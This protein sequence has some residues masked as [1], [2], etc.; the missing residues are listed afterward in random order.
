MGKVAIDKDI[1]FSESDWPSSLMLDEVWL[2]VRRLLVHKLERERFWPSTNEYKSYTEKQKKLGDKIKSEVLRDILG[3][4]DYVYLNSE[5]IFG[6]GNRRFRTKLPYVAAFGYNIGLTMHKLIGGEEEEGYDVFTICSIFNIGISIFDYIY[7]TDPKLFH[8]FENII[9]EKVL[10]TAINN[11]KTC[12]NLQANCNNIN[13]IELRLLS[14][15]IIWFFLKLHAFDIRSGKEDVWERLIS[16]IMSAYHAEINSTYH[17]RYSKADALNIS[18]NKS[19]LPFLVMYLIARL[20]P[21]STIEESEIDFTPLVIKMGEIFWHID[22]LIDVIR[23][24]E[25]NYLNSIITQINNKI[26]YID[27]PQRRYKILIELL[28]G[29]YIEAQANQICSK[30]KYILNF[31]KSKKNKEE[32]QKLVSNLITFSVRDWME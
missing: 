29:D 8:E 27:N 31:L 7:D 26:D 18:R 6:A 25:P 5:L 2:R 21:S 3:D 9:N 32:D 12:E 28:E 23:D 19:T 4:V 16:C 17:N 1:V 13:S 20:S 24:L 22:D 15:L 11:K 30:I 10:L 14:K